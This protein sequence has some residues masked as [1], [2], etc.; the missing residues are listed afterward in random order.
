MADEYREL[1]ALQDLRIAVHALLREDAVVQHYESQLH[2]NRPYQVICR[3]DNETRS[4]FRI[5]ASEA[6]ADVVVE[7]SPQRAIVA[8]VKGSD[9]DRAVEQLRNT[10]KY[11]RSR[12]IMIE[13]KIF[14]NRAA[15]ASG[16]TFIHGLYAVMRVFNSSFPGEWLL[17]EHAS[18]EDQQGQFVRIGG[19]V[20]SIVFG[21]LIARPV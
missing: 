1:K 16:R 14:L 8:E 18:P 10:Y 15:P 2:G 7:V 21:P 13:P 12:Y 9:I 11:A 19:M 17:I 5:P 3:T 20:V 6:A 4:V